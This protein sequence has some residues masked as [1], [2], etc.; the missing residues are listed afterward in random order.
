MRIPR[1]TRVS[2]SATVTEMCGTKSLAGALSTAPS[3]ST[4]YTKVATN[5]PRLNWVPISRMKLRNMRGP[6]CWDASWSTRMVI[7]KTTPATVMTAAAIAMRICRAASGL[8]LV[9]NAGSGKA[10]LAARRSRP[11]VMPNSAAIRTTIALGTIH[12]VVRIASRRARG[13]RNRPNQRLVPGRLSFIFA[14]HR[15]RDADAADQTSRRSPSSIRP[16]ARHRLPTI[17]PAA[18]HP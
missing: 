16:L 8:P 18:R 7:E 9:T 10:W 15:G 5:A 14:R 13:T 4:E 2:A 11:Y 3:A 6:N 17:C 1:S 12:S